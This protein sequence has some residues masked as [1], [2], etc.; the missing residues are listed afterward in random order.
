MAIVKATTIAIT[1]AR[2][3]KTAG[4]TSLF[5]TVHSARIQVDTEVGR[6]LPGGRQRHALF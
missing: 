6:Q 4:E 2:A 5:L 3:I 1:G